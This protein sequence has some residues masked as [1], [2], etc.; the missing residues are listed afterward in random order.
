MASRG[1]VAHTI[2]SDTSRRK[3]ARP[4]QSKNTLTDNPVADRAVSLWITL[5]NGLE[6]AKAL[7]LAVER[8]N[9]KTVRDYIAFNCGTA[10]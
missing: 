4:I 2:K 8:L 6:L 5:Y 3:T 1:I 10:V 9:I 7:G